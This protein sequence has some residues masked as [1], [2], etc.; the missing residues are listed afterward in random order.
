MLVLLAQGT[1]RHF[2]TSAL[3]PKIVAGAHGDAGQ[4]M[5]EGHRVRKLRQ[6]DVGFDEDLMD[7]FPYPLSRCASA[8]DAADVTLIPVDELGKPLG[9]ALP[10]PTDKIALLSRR[11]F[12]G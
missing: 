3:S 1:H 5:F 12:D 6:I 2:L 8:D 9:L 10:D 7:E 4:P 11:S